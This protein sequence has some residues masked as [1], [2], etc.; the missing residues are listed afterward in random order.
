MV[1]I[2]MM[3]V[4]VVSIFDGRQVVNALN[5]LEDFQHDASF[6]VSSLD[7]GKKIAIYSQSIPRSI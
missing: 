1:M 2:S 5:L 3:M 4:V 6:V 7:G